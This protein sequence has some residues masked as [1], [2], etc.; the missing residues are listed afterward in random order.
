MYASGLAVLENQRIDGEGCGRKVRRRGRYVWIPAQRQI[1][2]QDHSANSRAVLG[3]GEEGYILV[4]NSRSEEI[5]CQAG[6]VSKG[7]SSN[8]LITC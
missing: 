5:P 2:C 4:L 7:R 1:I 6:L 8:C 3:M